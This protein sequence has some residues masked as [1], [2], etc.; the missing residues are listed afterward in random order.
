MKHI[1]EYRDTATT[2]KTWTITECLKIDI[3]TL[4]LSKRTFAISNQEN[5]DYLILPIINKTTRGYVVVE[6]II[7]KTT[8]AKCTSGP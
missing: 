1:V 4:P 3:F 6:P 2:D 8:R 7:K 5:L